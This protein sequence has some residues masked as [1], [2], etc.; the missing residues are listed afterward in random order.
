MSREGLDNGNSSY[1]FADEYPLPD[2]QLSAEFQFVDDFSRSFPES[3]DLLHI[4]LGDVQRA[5]G[6]GIPK[7]KIES[8]SVPM[9]QALGHSD[10]GGML[11]SSTPSQFAKL[12][13]HLPRDEATADNTQDGWLVVGEM[14][15]ESRA[16][17]DGI[18]ALVGAKRIAD[19]LAEGEIYTI[20]RQGK[21]QD[22]SIY[23][24][25]KYDHRSNGDPTFMVMLVDQE[26]ARKFIEETA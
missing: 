13:L 17:V 5:A 24:E 6:I 23:F 3:T 25:E 20:M 10:Q 11:P 15:P 22:A 16:L 1:H 19:G 12:R 4:G 9:A 8:P 2:D 7:Y 14:P 18:Y 26:N 21:Y